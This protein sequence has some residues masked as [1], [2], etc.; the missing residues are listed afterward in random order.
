MIRLNRLLP[1]FL[2]LA[3]MIPS[4][5]YAT[6]Q[7]SDP[8]GLYSHLIAHIFFITTMA[9]LA[10]QIKRSKPKQKG[11]GYVGI[12]AV[13]FILWNIDTF[14]VHLIR[15]SM[16]NGEF[17][18]TSGHWGR[19]IDLTG[20]KAKLFYLGKIFDHVFLVSAVFVFLKGVIAFHDE[21]EMEDW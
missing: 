13:L 20:L 10:I 19:A 9:I 2:V 3:I 1:L 17:S 6:Q 15:E 12:A 11:W 21:S 5:A 16:D 4:Y 14:T 7:H 8:E 18:G